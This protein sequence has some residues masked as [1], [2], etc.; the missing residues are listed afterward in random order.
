[1]NF[2]VRVIVR[3]AVLT[4]MCS[5]FFRVSFANFW[6]RT[7]VKRCGVRNRSSPSPPRGSFWYS[8]VSRVGNISHDRKAHFM[9]DPKRSFVM[10][11]LL[12]R[13]SLSSKITRQHHLKWHHDVL[14]SK[15]HPPPLNLSDLVIS[16]ISYYA[17]RNQK[18][19][20]HKGRKVIRRL[21]CIQYFF[22]V[23]RQPGVHICLITMFH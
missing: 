4:V 5:G 10:Q 21:T 8:G 12:F 2:R 7:S 14:A 20:S 3:P 13:K 19:A 17:G 22:R 18:C 16:I 6:R 1:M 23:E 9:R 11:S 15:L